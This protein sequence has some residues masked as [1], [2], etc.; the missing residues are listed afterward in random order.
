MEPTTEYYGRVTRGVANFILAKLYLNAEFLIGTPKWAEAAAACKDIMTNNNGGSWYK[1]VDNYKDMFKVKN[2]F[3][4]EGILAIPY[5]T[6]Y[7]VSD[8]YAFLIHM[9]TLPVALC[10]PLGIPANAW[11]GIVAQPDFM[12]SYETGDKRKA[13]TWMFGQMKDLS[14]NNLTIDVPDPSD[15]EKTV[16]V[17]YVIDPYMPEE[18]YTTHRTDLQGA[19]IGKWE[20][21][22]DGTLTGGQVGMENE[23]YIMRYA[24]VVLMYAEAMVRQNKGGEVVGNA[25]L[26]KIRTRAGLTPFTAGTLT[27]DNI[28]QERSHEL[29]VEGWHR[30]DMIRFGKYLGA[31]WNKPAKEEKDFNLSI[32]KSAL[33]A[34]PNLTK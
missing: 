7:T 28:Y 25:D 22:S 1:I 4:E 6:V 2:E 11:D 32:P 3:C 14:G 20:Y 10:A 23:F 19:R 29:A 9:S 15:P 18:A 26:Q 33:A 30:Q 34:N 17:P 16:T 24:D 8:H 13:W 27:L 12:A 31:W 21:Q 5:S